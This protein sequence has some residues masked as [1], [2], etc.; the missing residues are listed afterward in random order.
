LRGDE[1]DRLLLDVKAL[2]VDL[3]I[4][5]DHAA[6]RLMVEGLQRR[7]SPIKLLL[8]HA[9]HQQQVLL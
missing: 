9:A 4:G 8:N 2:L 5:C 1:L 7:D 3:P 6:G